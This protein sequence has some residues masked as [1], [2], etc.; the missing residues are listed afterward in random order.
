MNFISWAFVAL[1]LVT[2]AARVTI[3]RRKIEPPYV[4][5]LT[6][7]SLV[8]YGWHVPW[9]LG[10]LLFSAG[11]DYWAALALERIGAADVDARVA[12]RRRAVL[13][14]SLATN[15]GLL[16]FFKYTDFGLATTEQVLTAFGWSGT[17]PRVDLFL[18][19][20]I[21]FYTFQS[22]SYTID[23]YR[24]VLSP[25]RSFGPFLLYISFF[26]QLVAGPIVRAS[27]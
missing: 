2:L 18:P 25:V 8:F 24:G 13:F 26:P 7:A 22:M 1:F 19:M 14:V 9:Y 6:L 3:G 12:R 16:G 10:L 27:M 21:S 17:L 4:A 5:V 11:V 20:G 23:V 15:L